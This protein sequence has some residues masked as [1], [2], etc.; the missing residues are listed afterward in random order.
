M[1]VSDE[2][3]IELLLD[4]DEQALTYTDNKY[5]KLCRKVAYNIIGDKDEIEACVN[6]SYFRLWNA[7][8]P[9]HPKSLK[10][11]LCGIVRN[12]AVKIYREKLSYNEKYSSLSELVETFG[13]KT[14]IE[15]QL[16]G[17]LLGACINE[18]LS[19]TD[20]LNRRIFVLRYYYNTPL[21][22][23]AVALKI[24]DSTVGTKLH[25]TRE[26]LKNFLINKGYKL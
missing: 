26:K 2:Q 10:A 5:G 18:F 15:E 17:N 24:K 20:V 19:T 13:D 12:V 7:I 23:I 22:D 25:R 21:H 4:R 3:I 16:D 9:M 11:Y 1:S 8:P 6:N 14:G